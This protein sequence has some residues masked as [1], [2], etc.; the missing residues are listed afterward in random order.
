MLASA[1]SWPVLPC[2]SL[3]LSEAENVEI[4]KSMSHAAAQLFNVRFFFLLTVC[5]GSDFND[6]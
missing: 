3:V 1:K 5:Y 6:D 4:E 2:L